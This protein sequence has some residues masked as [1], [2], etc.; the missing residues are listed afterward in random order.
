MSVKIIKN[1]GASANASVPANVVRLGY[2]LPEVGAA[3]GRSTLWAHR[4]VYAGEL[5]VIRHGGRML[6][7]SAELER[8]AARTEVYSGRMTPTQYVKNKSPRNDKPT[9]PQGKADGKML[10]WNSISFGAPVTLFPGRSS[11]RPLTFVVEAV[12]DRQTRS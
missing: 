5:K 10:I 12:P 8:F 6:V 9:A 7:S 4:R 3:F 2:S 11:S 1:S